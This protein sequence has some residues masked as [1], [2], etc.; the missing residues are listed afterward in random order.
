MRLNLKEEFRNMSSQFFYVQLKFNPKIGT[1]RVPVT[2][3]HE[4]VVEVPRDLVERKQA[5]DASENSREKLIVLELARR[6]ALGTF[7][8][9]TERVIGLYDEDPPIWYEDRPHIMNERPCDNE[10]NGTRA[11]KVV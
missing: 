9:V 7:P 5:E 10:E 4:A 6:A 11:W 8:T 2:K 1:D 3:Q